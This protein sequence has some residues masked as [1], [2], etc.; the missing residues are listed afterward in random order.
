MA[1]PCNPLPST[2]PA[3]A[4]TECRS[5]ERMSHTVA[6]SHRC[7]LGGRS[8]GSAHR[9]RPP[10]L[11]RGGNRRSLMA[12]LW[13]RVAAYGKLRTDPVKGATRTTAAAAAAA[14]AESG[15]AA[16]AQHAAARATTRANETRRQTATGAG[17]RAAT[18]PQRG[19]VRARGCAVTPLLLR[20]SRR[21]LPMRL[22]L[23]PQTMALLARPHRRMRLASQAA[24]AGCRG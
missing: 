5:A 24:D 22:V 21:P 17:E 10:P 11:R 4:T 8:Q 20:M 3:R 2:A 9:A 23:L 6:A 18:A 13:A 14:A 12:P 15:A 7:A 16:A 1:Y 19:S